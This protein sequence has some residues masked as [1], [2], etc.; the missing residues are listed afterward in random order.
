MVLVHIRRYTKLLVLF[1]AFFSPFF[2]YGQKYSIG[3]KAGPLIN[4]ARFGDPEAREDLSSGV[5]LGYSAGVLVSFPLKHDFDFF[6]EAAY[7]Q[8]GR[9]LKF[10]PEDW[11]NQATYKF[12]DV[13]MLLR[14]SYTFRLEKNIPSQWYINI[15]PEISYWLSGKGYVT[16][17]GPNY[18]YKMVF[19]D[20]PE[21]SSYTTMYMK[22]ANRF[23]FGLALG[24][25]FRAPLLRSQHL[26]TEIRFVSGHTYLGNK[27]SGRLA[28]L[29]YAE[30][31]T[32]K[33]NLKVININVSYTL[34]FDVQKSRKGKS[35]LDKK[36][37]SS[38]HRRRR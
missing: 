17:E 3:V 15:G 10:E 12:I 20:N 8:K 6:A 34:D 24:V 1:F 29:N 7:S 14:K 5:K 36:I 21:T 23:L 30:T 22:D 28:Y 13:T 18:P 4:W 35:T 38:K 25:G 31:D 26:N 33:M 16:V 27:D 19:E 32:Y 37:K 11:L 9:R 2:S